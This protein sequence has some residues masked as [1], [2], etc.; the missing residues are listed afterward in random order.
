LLRNNKIIKS[1]KQFARFELTTEDTGDKAFEGRGT[2]T[3]E[4]DEKKND[5]FPKPSPKLSFTFFE[6]SVEQV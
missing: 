1:L 4:R 3:Y 2:N 6:K 5:F